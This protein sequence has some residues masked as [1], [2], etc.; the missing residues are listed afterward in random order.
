ML[1]G[2][3]VLAVIDTTAPVVFGLDAGGR[4]ARRTNLFLKMGGNA[5]YP[6]AFNEFILSVPAGRL[7]NEISVQSVDALGGLQ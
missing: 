1:L 4:T 2:I 5:R 7:Y 3:V 6:S